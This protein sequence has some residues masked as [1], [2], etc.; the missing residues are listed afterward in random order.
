MELTFNEWLKYGWDQGWC[1]PDVCVVHD[2]LPLSDF[3][4]ESW[5]DGDDCCIHFI[6]LYEDDSIRKAVEEGHSPTN[7]RAS[8][9]GWKRNAEQ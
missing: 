2:G 8:N 3:E 6:R 9:L 5:Y 7:W 4:T 1:G